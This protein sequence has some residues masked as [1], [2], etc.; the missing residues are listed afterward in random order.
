LPRVFPQDTQDSIERL[1]ST[2]VLDKFPLYKDFWEK[3]VGVRPGPGYLRPYGLRFDSTVSATDRKETR[4]TYEELS[5][6]HYTLFC[7]LSGAHFQLANLRASVPTNGDIQ[8]QFNHWEA[9][10]A[11]YLHLA[12][13]VNQ[14]YHLWGLALLM[15]GKLVRSSGG[16]INGV[17]PTLN[18]VLV[19]LRKGRL[20]RDLVK[21]EDETIFLRHSMTHFA[22]GASRH[23]EGRY[24]IP[25]RMRTNRVWT[26]QWRSRKY[27]GTRARAWK[28]INRVRQ[29]INELHA[30]L[31]QRLER[32][33]QS[34]G[35]KVNY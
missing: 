18:K 3:F 30:L 1:Y 20:W 4:L 17:R 12:I 27:V 13:A 15:E 10:E 33:F 32:T 16:T 24:F 9:F 28:D 14:V 35:I 8:R 21:L 29:T 11:I 22:R 5:M 7:H 23:E 31:I 19:S 25:L 34:R 26:R 6:A 2:E